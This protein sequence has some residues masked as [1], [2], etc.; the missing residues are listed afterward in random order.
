MKKVDTHLHA[1]FSGDSK[2]KYDSLFQKA[3]SLKYD[4]LAITEHFDL[5]DSEILNYGLISLKEY[6]NTINIMQKKY[7][8]I[9]IVKGLELG[10]PHRIKEFSD[11]L[12]INNKPDFIIGSLH[13]TKSNIAVSLP[14]ENPLSKK[15]LTEYYEENLEMVN[16]NNFDSLGHLGI[17]KRDYNSKIEYCES[18]CEIIIDEIFKIMIKNEISLEINNSGFRTKFNNIIPDPKI[19]KRYFNLG[20]KL[21]NISSDAHDLSYFDLFYN[22]TLDIISDLGFISIYYKEDNKW[23]DILID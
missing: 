23:C 8:S 15:D 4:Y 16:A 7:P 12:F 5:L 13:L 3:I 19:L 10:E 2:I 11:R 18:H 17:F 22:K 20:G 14:L 21:I 9:K 6:Y 1:D